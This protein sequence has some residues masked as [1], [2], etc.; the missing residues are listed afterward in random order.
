M[1]RKTQIFFI[2]GGMTFKNKKDYLNYLRTRK[3]TLD[4]EYI[5]RWSDEYLKN[6]LGRKFQTIRPRMPNKE[7]SKYEAWKINFENYIPHLT[8]NVILIGESLG[9]IFLAKYL[10]ENKL[11][12]KILSVYLVAA[13]FDGEN[14]GFKLKDDLSLLEKNSK[15][16]YLLF[17][18]DDDIVPVGHAKKYRNK[19]KGAKIFILEGKNG[20]FSVPKLPEIIKLIKKDIKRK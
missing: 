1:K 12:K 16:L 20:H 5:V 15:N 2:H 13:P 4:Y 6:E 3:L 11:S 8:D 7:D 18:K 19:L 14:G 10:S 17:S 9:G